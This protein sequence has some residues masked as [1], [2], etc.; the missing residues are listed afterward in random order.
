MARSTDRARARAGRHDSCIKNWRI[1]KARSSAAS[2]L[3][4]C[5]TL[6]MFCSLHI[7]I[8]HSHL[9]TLND[10]LDFKVILT[11]ARLAISILETC[12]NKMQAK[13]DLQV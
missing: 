3:T 9:I 11:P 4:A 13:M 8:L 6:K 1:P 12:K 5:G 10:A 2:T 7:S